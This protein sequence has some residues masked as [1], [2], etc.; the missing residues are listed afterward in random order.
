M[1]AYVDKDMLYIPNDVCNVIPRLVPENVTDIIVHCTDTECT[2]AVTLDTIN[3]WHIARGFKCIG[4]HFVIYPDGVCKV[5][6]PLQLRGAHAVMYNHCSVGVCY[7]GGRVHG[8]PKDSRTFAQKI[9]LAE[10]FGYIIRHFPNV[11]KI[12]GHNDVSAKLCPCFDAKMEYEGFVE[13]YRK[14]LNF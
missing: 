3:S 8:N 7:V 6:R 5:A 13:K 10:C 2:S 11:D 12:I 9:S 1:Q 14:C 4:Y